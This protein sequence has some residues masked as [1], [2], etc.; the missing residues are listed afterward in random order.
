MELRKKIKD[1]LGNY[2]PDEMDGGMYHPN[3]LLAEE[4]LLRLFKKWALEMVG[5]PSE[6]RTAPADGNEE[7]DFDYGYD[8][9]RKEILERINK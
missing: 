7:K 5:E 8:V 6:I 9:A 3:Q 2:F 4:A 1:T